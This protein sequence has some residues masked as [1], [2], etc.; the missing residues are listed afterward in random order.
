MMAAF[1]RWLDKVAYFLFTRVSNPLRSWKAISVIGRRLGVPNIGISCAPSAALHSSPRILIVRNDALGDLLLTLPFIAAMRALF[2]KAFIALLVAPAWRALVAKLQIVDEVLSCALPTGRWSA[3]RNVR[4]AIRF[5]QRE[6]EPRKF[7]WVIVPRWDADFTDSFLL[8]FFSFAPVRVAYSEEST[9]WRRVSNVGMDAFYTCVVTD[10]G[11]VHESERS[12]RLLER[13]GFK[14]PDAYEKILRTAIDDL[15]R[16]A[17]KDSVVLPKDR[18]VIGVFPSV[19]DPIKQWPI[20][21]F[22]EMV[23][24]VVEKRDCMFVVFGGKSDAGKC[25]EFADA[26]PAPVSNLCDRVALQDLPDVLRQCAV[27]LSCDSGGAHLAGIMNLSVVV[28]FSQTR[29]YDPAGQL[30][31]ERFKPLGD[32]VVVIQPSLEAASQQKE[33]PP[34]VASVSSEAMAHALLAFLNDQAP[35]HTAPAVV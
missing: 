3:V 28:I 22:V 29:G 10:E 21:R 5:G 32:R 16:P 26:C 24:Q 2:P 19:L 8:A 34:P 33:G 35:A 30:S 27:I 1:H 31:P 9:A 7:D 18:A 6:L 25:A 4:R 15:K 20:S 14:V 17:S 23:R 13:M 12:L 11:V